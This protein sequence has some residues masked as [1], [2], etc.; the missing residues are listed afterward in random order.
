MFMKLD[1]DW[2]SPFFFYQTIQ[3][4]Y[5]LKWKGYSDAENTWEPVEN[6]DCQDLIKQYEEQREEE[7]VQFNI[8][9]CTSYIHYIN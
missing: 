5:F 3:V 9:L 7:E 1:F 4:E 2:I 8:S 6:L